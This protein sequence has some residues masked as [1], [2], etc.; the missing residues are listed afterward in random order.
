MG[1]VCPWII[2]VSSLHNT[3]FFKKEKKVK[4]CVRL[5]V[6]DQ[7]HYRWAVSFPDSKCNPIMPALEMWK[8]TLVWSVV[9]VV[10]ASS[11]QACLSKRGGDRRIVLLMRL[12]MPQVRA[13]KLCNIIWCAHVG[14]V[15]MGWGSRERLALITR[16]SCCLWSR[17][18]ALQARP[19]E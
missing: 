8:V 3:I 1:A 19:I 12:I 6:H 14:C 5:N 18:H 15:R 11:S 2:V 10:L 17:I 9:I 7:R 4:K 16:E 13:G